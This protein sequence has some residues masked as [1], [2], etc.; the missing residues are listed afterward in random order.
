MFYQYYQNHVFLC[1]IMDTPTV[2]KIF[3]FEFFYSHL[4]Y[5]PM[6]Y[7]QQMHLT[8]LVSIIQNPLRRSIGLAENLSPSTRHYSHYYQQRISWKKKEKINDRDAVHTQILYNVS[9]VV[10]SCSR[11]YMNYSLCI[12]GLI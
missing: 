8:R 4:H 10:L 5:Q 2:Y 1:F 6:F 7:S 12:N 3:K 9:P 11:S